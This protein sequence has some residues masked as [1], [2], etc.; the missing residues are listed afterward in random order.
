MMFDADDFPDDPYAHTVNQAGHAMLVGVPMAM[1][2]LI[3]LPPW[4]VPIIVAALYGAVWEVLIQPQPKGW[5]DS[6]M[7]TACVMGGASVLCGAFHFIPGEA[8]WQAWRTVAV[9]FLA[10]GGLVLLGGLRRWK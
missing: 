3:L 2:G 9:A 10:Y 5:A 8:F 7:D 6:I 1:L 4:L